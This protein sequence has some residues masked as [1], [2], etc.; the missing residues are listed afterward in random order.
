M[1]YEIRRELS[2]RWGNIGARHAHR[3]AEEEEENESEEE[4]IEW[5]LASP[6]LTVFLAVAILLAVQSLVANTCR[7][8]RE[9]RRKK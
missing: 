6:N 7:V 2:I 9:H 4:M 1:A 5:C 8:L 3:G